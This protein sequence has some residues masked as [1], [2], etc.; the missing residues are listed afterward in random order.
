MNSLPASV[1]ILK[2]VAYFSSGL[3]ATSTYRYYMKKRHSTN[4]LVVKLVA[5]VVAYSGFQH[6]KFAAYMLWAMFEHPL[7]LDLSSSQL[8]TFI[9]YKQSVCMQ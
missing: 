7:T 1:T 9:L 3:R 4:I 5:V 6:K 2:C 8:D